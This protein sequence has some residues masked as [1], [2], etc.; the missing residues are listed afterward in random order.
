DISLEEAKKMGVNIIPLIVRMNNKDY[1]DGVDL[2][3]KQ[4]YDMLIEYNELP[5]TSQITPFRYVEKYKE[6][7]ADGST[8][9]VITISS[10][11]SG[12]YASAVA[13]ADDFPN[14]YVV[15]SLNACIGER[16]LCEYALKLINDNLDINNI[17]DELNNAKKRINVIAMLNTLEYLKKGGRISGAA[18]F[19]GSR[20]SLKPVIGV[21][22][23]SVKLLG[24][25]IG[26]KKGKNLLNSLVEEKGIDFT[27]PFGTVYSG[28]DDSLLTKYIEDSE[29]IWKSN[30]DNVPKYIIGTTIGTH[31][32]P[33]GIGVA[34][35]EKKS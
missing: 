10:K 2:T 13:A 11:L 28:L 4:F 34:F 23:G 9:L 8:L 26:S 1:Y 32:G 29:S 17:V 12:T 3:P 24:K 14:V 16:L 22:N 15:D 27:M 31:V 7:T 19:I 30:T 35:F 21:V 25:A 20:L 18:A 33:N 6:L 5:K